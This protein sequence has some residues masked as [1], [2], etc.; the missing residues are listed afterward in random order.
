MI[1]KTQ[2]FGEYEITVDSYSLISKSKALPFQIEDSIDTD[3]N[4][5]LKYR[6][7]DLRRDDMKRNILARSNT[8][9][10]IGIQWTAYLF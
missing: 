4:I 3:E 6:Y 5:R 7:L 1:N 8:F 9:K 10:T 2:Q